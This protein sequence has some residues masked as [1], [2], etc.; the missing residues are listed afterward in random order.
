MK[1]S[2]LPSQNDVRRSG[3]LCISVLRRCSNGPGFYAVHFDVET[4]VSGEFTPFGCKEVRNGSMTSITR[5]PTEEYLLLPSLL[6][7]D[8]VTLTSHTI[9]DAWGKWCF[10]WLRPVPC[11]LL[12]SWVGTSP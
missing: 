8:E 7:F 12:G 11:D 6:G 1:F 5:F 9:H 2:N 4:P 3:F 10:D